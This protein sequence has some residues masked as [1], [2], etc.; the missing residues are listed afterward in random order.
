MTVLVSCGGH[1]WIHAV[2]GGAVGGGAVGLRGREAV[3]RLDG[4]LARA[5]A[6]AGRDA[7]GR[8]GVQAAVEGRDGEVV[9]RLRGDAAGVTQDAHHLK[10]HRGSC[11]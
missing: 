7:V 8:R 9:L 2:A 10:P 6:A 1:G 11:F 5:L 3:H 4:G